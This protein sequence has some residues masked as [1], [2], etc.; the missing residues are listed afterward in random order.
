MADK[1]NQSA[2]PG[3]QDALPVVAITSA[4]MEFLSDAIQNDEC[5]LTVTGSNYR[6]M[7]QPQTSATPSNTSEQ[8]I[9]TDTTA[10]SDSNLLPEKSHASLTRVCFIYI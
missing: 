4:S 5:T 8:T 2:A 9:A 3:G 1:C 7:L 10:G 6:H